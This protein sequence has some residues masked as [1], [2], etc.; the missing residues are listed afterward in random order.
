M[1]RSAIWFGILL[2]WILPSNTSRGDLLFEFGVGEV[3]TSNIEIPGPGATVP[4]QVYLRETGATTILTDFGLLAAG[5]RVTIDDPTVARV[6]AVG[7]IQQNPAFD[8]LLFLEKTLSPDYQDAE[9]IMAVDVFDDSP[10]VFPDGDGRVL[11]GTFS[12]TGLT[13]GTTN[14]RATALPGEFVD[15]FFDPITETFSPADATTLTVTPEPGSVA[16]SLVA[17]GGAAVVG[18]YRSRRKRR[19]TSAEDPPVVAG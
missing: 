5:I 16:L 3:I 19:K 2:I 7:N 12:F 1:T 4:I 15:G 14:I 13:L 9:L 6:S 17:L 11:L 8:D 10:I 18:V